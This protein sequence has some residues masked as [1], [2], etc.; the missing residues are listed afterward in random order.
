MSSNL[1]KRM[2]KGV[3][4]ASLETERNDLGPDG[5]D[6]LITVVTSVELLY[7]PTEASWRALKHLLCSLNDEMRY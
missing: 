6:E 4:Y 3:V 5:E 7:W 2:S 1:A